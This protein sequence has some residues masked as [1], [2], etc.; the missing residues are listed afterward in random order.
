MIQPLL[1]PSW[2]KR[3]LRSGTLI[4]TSTTHIWGWPILKPIFLCRSSNPH[5]KLVASQSSVYFADPII[6]IQGCSLPNPA[7]ASPFSC[8]VPEVFH[9]RRQPSPLPPIASP[10]CW[11]HLNQVAIPSTSLYP[12]A[13]T[14]TFFLLVHLCVPKVPVSPFG[15]PTPQLDWSGPVLISNGPSPFHGRPFKLGPKRNPAES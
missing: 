3:S 14:A 13:A 8:F 4:A 10:H 9:T 5:S 11:R 2:S 12:P 1:K 7:A 6:H 15:F